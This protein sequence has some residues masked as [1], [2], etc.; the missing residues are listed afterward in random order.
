MLQFNR[1][2]QFDFDQMCTTGTIERQYFDQ[3]LL[4]TLGD[5]V[6]GDFFIDP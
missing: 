3:R 4:V 6:V 1:L 2:A 5:A